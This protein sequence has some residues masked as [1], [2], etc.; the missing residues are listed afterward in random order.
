MRKILYYQ[1][2]LMR[3]VHSKLKK[4]EFHYLDALAEVEKLRWQKHLL[5]QAMGKG[6]IKRGI[7]QTQRNSIDSAI[8]SLRKKYL[9]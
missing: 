2:G 7:Y 3:D 6:F 8:R 9:R 5:D 1:H 4:G